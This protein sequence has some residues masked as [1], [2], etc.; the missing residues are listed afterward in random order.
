MSTCFGFTRIQTFKNIN[1]I[2][3]TNITVDSRSQI[4]IK[5]SSIYSL[6]ECLLYCDALSLCVGFAQNKEHCFIC[7]NST[8]EGDLV[9]VHMQN[10]FLIWRDYLL[11]LPGK[12]GTFISRFW[13]TFLKNVL[14]HELLSFLRNCQYFQIKWVHGYYIHI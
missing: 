6:Q 8:T 11:E 9:P 5:H 10:R 13:F 12:K 1:V 7:D 2:P 14:I 3:T 4:H